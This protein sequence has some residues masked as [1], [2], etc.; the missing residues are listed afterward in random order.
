MF[1]SSGNEHYGSHQF[2]NWWQQHATGML[3][4]NRFKSPPSPP[5]KAAARRR[6]FIGGDGGI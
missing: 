5:I 2:L 6:R 4:L 1:I 3:H